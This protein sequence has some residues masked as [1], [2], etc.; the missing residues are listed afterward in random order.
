MFSEYSF[1]M[2][3]LSNTVYLSE[4]ADSFLRSGWLI[5]TQSHG[6]FSK[7]VPGEHHKSL[8]KDGNGLQH[9]LYGLV[10]FRMQSCLPTQYWQA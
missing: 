2:I 3:M 4:A 7:P 9:L 1:R 8:G 10:A 5:R 6:D